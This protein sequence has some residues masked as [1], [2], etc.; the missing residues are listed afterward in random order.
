VITAVMR[1]RRR[2]RRIHAVDR[3]EMPGRGGLAGRANA[4]ER[5]EGPDRVDAL[6]RV[7]GLGRAGVVGRRVFAGRPR[8]FAGV[9]VA[10][11]AV[12]GGLLAGPAAGALVAAYGLMAAGY[13]ARWRGDRALV[14][15]RC[16]ALDALAVLAADLRAGLAP[17]TVMPAA[18]AVLDDVPVIRARL[19]AAGQVAEATGAPLADLLDRLEADLR[20]VERVRRTV[21]AHAA[22]IRATAGLLAVL[23][24][25]GIGVG[26]GMGADP[27]YVLLRTPIGMAAAG[28]AVLLQIAGLAWAGRLTRV[29]GERDA[30]RPGRGRAV[31]RRARGRVAPH[32]G[33]GAVP[34]P[35]QGHR[36]LRR[37]LVA[38]LCAAA[39]AVLVGGWPG[40]LAGV[41]TGLLLDR[42]LGRLEPAERRRDREQAALDL[43]YAADLLAVTLRAGLPTERA[44][45]VVAEAVG[46]PVGARLARTVGL[47]GLGLAPQRAW[48]ALSDLPAGPR[49]AQAVA[50]SADSGAALAVALS[51]LADDL[52]TA[53]L[54]EA[55]AGAHRAGVLLVLPLGLCFLPAF[56][57]AGIGPVIVA[58]LG[59]V[60]S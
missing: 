53:R 54:A 58:V 28:M 6:G 24:L 22:G 34:R 2:L 21:A 41:L 26:Y 47:L 32:P 43:P 4:V 51:R 13:A 55:E 25:A 5:V 31:P 20:G 33:R 56:I 45:Q 27:L 17:A 1:T 40:L 9:L 38:A 16:R 23:P 49:I 18:S 35:D 15:A 29:G 19:S 46:G 52:R 44:V 60:L 14:S 10:G 3:R 39:T 8:L 59:D 48:T 50:R 11:A 36:G 42:W 37:R 12:L 7:D 30:I 57:L